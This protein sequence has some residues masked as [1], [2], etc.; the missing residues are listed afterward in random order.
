MIKS[1]QEDNR[2]EVKKKDKDDC[3]LDDETSNAIKDAH[4]GD[5]PLFSSPS[6]SSEAS[7]VS[8]ACIL[9]KQY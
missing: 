4:V 2:A 5:A 8:T 3:G 7:L 6:D 1:L 9:S